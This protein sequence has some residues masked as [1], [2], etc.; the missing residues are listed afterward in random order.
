MYQTFADLEKSHENPW[1]AVIAPYL[2]QRIYTASKEAYADERMIPKTVT[3][4]ETNMVTVLLRQSNGEHVRVYLW[5]GTR[6]EA[7]K[8][9]CL[10]DLEEPIGKFVFVKTTIP[11]DI[12]LYTKF[13]IIEESTDGMF[14]DD[15]V[16]AIVA[17]SPTDVKKASDEV[18]AAVIQKGVERFAIELM[19]SDMTIVAVYL[20]NRKQRRGLP[21]LFEEKD[22]LIGTVES[23]RALGEEEDS[24]SEESGSEDSDYEVPTSDHAE[25]AEFLLR[26]MESGDD[27]SESESASGSGSEESSYNETDAKV[28][29]LVAIHNEVMELVENKGGLDVNRKKIEALW[30]RMI[31]LGT[32]EEYSDSEESDS[33]DPPFDLMDLGLEEDD[34]SSPAP[35]A[36]AA[37]TSK[38]LPRKAKE[39]VRSTGAGAGAGAGAADYEESLVEVD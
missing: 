17:S 14:E 36:S 6:D 8:A 32:I 38:N 29:E 20:T 12:E 4:Y 33:E 7:K 30:M 16:S 2:A 26:Q 3:V 19:S 23:I 22:I 10:M 25:A 39:V 5:V 31:A 34:S 18:Y 15:Q 27:D 11:H 28:D 21:T 13:E 37:P 35:A 1:G 24:G 9:N